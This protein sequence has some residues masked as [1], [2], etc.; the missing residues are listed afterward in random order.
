VTDPDRAPGRVPSPGV[1]AR[2]PLVALVA[3]V[4]EHGAVH[5]GP[6]DARRAQARDLAAELRRI[7]D[8]L[9][10]TDAPVEELV[11]ATDRARAFADR[12]AELA[13]RRSY[14][15][16]AEASIGMGVQFLDNSPV[17]GLA[18]P[19]AP[20]MVL[21]HVRRDAPGPDGP[22]IEV[23]ARANLSWAYEGPP[24]SV[25]GGFVAALF[26]DALG[27][28]MAAAGVAGFTGTLTVRY[29][30]PT[31]IVT[32]LRLTA[33]V[34]R[35]DGRKLFTAGTIHAGDVLCAEAEAVFV[36]ISQDRLEQMMAARLDATPD[37]V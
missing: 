27:S 35:Q 7:I 26:D 14:Q 31:P 15:G 5:E 36:T 8:H 34:E 10:Q 28:A 18:N 13:R 3:A 37:P 22:R 30:N 17:M 4:D 32:D 24:G 9:V 1:T 20:P 33:W 25:H 19:I 16:V 23:E 12:L 6:V 2:H 21:T 11:A 29:R